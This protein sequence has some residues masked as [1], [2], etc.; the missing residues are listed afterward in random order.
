MGAGGGFLPAEASGPRGEKMAEGV[1]AGMLALGPWDGLHFDAASGAFH[2]AHSLGEGDRDVPNGDELELAGKGHVIV[3]WTT[4]LAAGADEPGVRSGD[5]G[6][7]EARL[8]SLATHFDRM[9]N[10]ALE[11]V[12][13]VE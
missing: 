5:N 1:A 9:V 6:G 7:D 3:S 2:P 13:F 10:E 4:F 12:D 8:V 11:A